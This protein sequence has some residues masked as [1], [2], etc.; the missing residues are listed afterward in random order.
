MPSL[1]VAADYR[2][3]FSDCGP[4]RML[5]AA[6]P[7]QLPDLRI[8]HVVMD[9]G[10][11]LRFGIFRPKALRPAEIR[12]ARFGGDPGPRAA[13]ALPSRVGRHHASVPP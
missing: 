8:R 7:R 11:P 6:L 12:N 10:E 13:Q 3:G 4:R 1:S 5:E 9:V 2:Q